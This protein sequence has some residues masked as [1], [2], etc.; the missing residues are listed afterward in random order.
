MKA[1]LS[2]GITM[3]YEEAGEGPPLV[4]MAGTSLD[5]RAWYLQMAAFVPHFRVIA[6]DHRG[7][8]QTDA[9]AESSAYSSKLMGDDIAALLDVLR[10]ERAHVSGMS[11]GSAATQEMAINHADRVL[12][13]QLHATWGRTDAWF[14]QGFVDPM[15]YFLKAKERR[16]AFKFGQALIM[17]PDYLNTKDPPEVADMVERCLI[18]NPHLAR[19]SGFGG[20]LHADATHDALDRLGDIRAPTLITAGELDMNTPHRYGEQVH[21]CIANSVYHLFRGPRASHVAM[22]EMADAFN[23]VCLDFLGGAKAA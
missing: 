3:F 17:S 14:R 20:Q 5:H 15:L 1:A 8:G 2:T 6:I 13:V 11:L 18:K 21:A 4:L 22:W 7:A 10:I 12:S 23:R 9:P 16:A 19:D